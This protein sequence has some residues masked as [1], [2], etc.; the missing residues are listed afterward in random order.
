VKRARGFT[1]IELMVALAIVGMIATVA[2]PALRSRSG[3]RATAQQLASI[4]EAAREA[5]IA[6]GT[7]ADVLLD[8]PNGV[9]YVV[10]EARPGRPAD[11]IRKGQLGL[12][13]GA[14]LASQPTRALHPVVD[15]RVVTT[16]DAL[17]RARGADVVVAD[18]RGR[19]AVV[20]TDPWTGASRVQAP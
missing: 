3:A 5:A 11:T 4:Y 9:Y 17:G 20:V 18:D 10:T 14:R 16:F 13:G 2:V 12:P 6:R 7:S 8:L 19:H 15:G 1:L